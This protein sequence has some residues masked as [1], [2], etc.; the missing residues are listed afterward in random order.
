MDVRFYETEAGTSPVIDYLRT[1]PREQRQIAGRAIRALQNA[2][3]LAEAHVD[4]RPIKGKLWEIR[5]SYQRVFY[6]IAARNVWWL[7]HA[8][9]KDTNKTPER[10]KDVALRRMREVLAR[11]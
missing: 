1:L 10:E 9:E 11:R 3:T 7:L 4:V 8:Y 2:D 5:A 6:V